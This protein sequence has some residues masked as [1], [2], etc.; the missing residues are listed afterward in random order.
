MKKSLKIRNKLKYNKKSK[1][2]KNE[3]R[4][5]NK[6]FYIYNGGKPTIP[7]IETTKNPS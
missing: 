2:S 4:L 7:L 6:S 3:N 1:K 5:V